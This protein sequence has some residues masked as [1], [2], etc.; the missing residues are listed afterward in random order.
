MNLLVIC[1]FL[2]LFS[3][4]VCAAFQISHRQHSKRNKRK[5]RPFLLFAENKN[6]KNNFWQGVV[7]L[8]DEIIE[9]STYG[10]SERKLLKARREAKARKVDGIDGGDDDDDMSLDSFRRA[11]NQLSEQATSPAPPDLD[12]DGY[13]M[14]DLLLEKW[15]APLDIDFQ[16]QPGVVCC[17]ILPVAF[18]SHKCRHESELEYLMHLQGI[19]EVLHKYNNLDL[20][21]DFIITTSKVPKVGTD[22][23]PFRLEL[24]DE[25]LELIL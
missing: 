6:E 15:N 19:V 25:D 3:P 14:R 20:F 13:A 17:T 7:G 2:I 10:P 1:L 4:Q 12:F 22:S 18:G 21:I 23:V 24:T 9:V 11:T 16:R 8:W 5:M